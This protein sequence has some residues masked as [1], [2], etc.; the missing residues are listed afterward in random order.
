MTF[1][2]L[3]SLGL[4]LLMD[5]SVKLQDVDFMLN[6]EHADASVYSG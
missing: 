1:N 5:N 3:A 2:S 6:L 4:G